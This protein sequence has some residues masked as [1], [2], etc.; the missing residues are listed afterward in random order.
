MAGSVPNAKWASG[1]PQVILNEDFVA[2]DEAITKQQQLRLMPPLVYVDAATVRVEATADCP[3]ETMFV[4]IPNVLNPNTFVNGGLSDNAKR[5]N[6]SN[7]SMIFTSG[8]IWGAEK[9]SQWYA[10][11]GISAGAVNSTFTLKAM[12]WIRVHAQVSQTIEF[13]TNLDA[14]T[15]IGYGFTANEFTGGMIYVVTGASK[16]LMRTITLN[17]NGATSPG[18]VTYSGTALSLSQGDW[19]IIL[20]STNFKWLGDV[21]NNASSNITEVGDLIL[22]KQHYFFTANDNWICPFTWNALFGTGIGGGSG[23][24]TGT[25]G[26]YGVAGTRAIKTKYAPTPGTVYAVTMGSAGL[27]GGGPTSGGATTLGA[28]ISLAGGVNYNVGPV[29]AVGLWGYGNGGDPSIPTN[30]KA[31]C[32]LIEKE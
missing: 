7:V 11:L 9:A 23:A 22:G 12:P 14:T 31:G 5:S 24:N 17:S 30:G 21:W 6:I 13:G 25:P 26:L 32:L 15:H 27:S 3:A 8:D 18:T 16:G 19:F 29:D 4:G 28:L 10:I 2:Y 20:P 1:T